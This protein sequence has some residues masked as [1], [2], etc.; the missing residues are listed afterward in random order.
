MRIAR[1]QGT[2]NIDISTLAVDMRFAHNKESQGRWEE[3]DE[4]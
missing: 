3:E 4:W 1:E 2:F